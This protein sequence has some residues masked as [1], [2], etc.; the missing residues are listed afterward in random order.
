MG[1]FQA[2]GFG[3]T[4][5]PPSVRATADLRC[6]QTYLNSNKFMMRQCNRARTHAVLYVSD[7]DSLGLMATQ[8][9]IPVT[10][11][12]HRADD[13][14][15]VFSNWDDLVDTTGKRPAVNP[16]TDSTGLLWTGALGTATC[17]SWTTLTGE[18]VVGN[19]L[20]MAANWLSREGGIACDTLARLLCICW[21]GGE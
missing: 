18:G 6:V 11:P 16:I 3:G 21:A 4:D 13:D 9:S 14:A 17:N 12:V 8:Y 10:V 1:T 15:A 7:G 2:D 19:G 5:R 20:V